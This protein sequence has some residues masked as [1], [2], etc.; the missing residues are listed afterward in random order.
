MRTLRNYSRAV[1]FSC[2]AKL[3]EID[4]SEIVVSLFYRHR[5]KYSAELDKIKQ[6]ALELF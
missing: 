6:D 5:A 2:E 1:L 4:I 3:Q